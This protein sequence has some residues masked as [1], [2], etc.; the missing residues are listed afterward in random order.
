VTI[1]APQPGPAEVPRRGGGVELGGLSVRYLTRSSPALE[2]VSVA[3]R[4]GE[5]VGVAGRNGAGKSTLALAAA[6]FIP[7]I[8]RAHISGAVSI[9]GRPV[10]DLSNAELRRSVGIVFAT[11]AN[12]LSASKLTVREEL[13]FGLENLGF[14]RVLMEAR[15]DEVLSRLHIEHLADRDPLALSG[16]EQQRVAIASIVAMG[17]NALVLDEPTAQLDPAG[18]W[19]VADLL[20]SLTE[21]GVAVMCTEHASAVLARTDRCLVL[22]GG[23]GV[24]LD[25]PGLAL[26]DG[27]LAD[28]EMQPPTMAILADAA[29]VPLEHAFDE[30]RIASAIARRRDASVADASALVADLRHAMFAGQRPGPAIDLL[31]QRPAAAIEAI[32]LRHVYPGGVEAVR[33]VSLKVEPGES[34]AIVGQNGSGKTTLV[35]HFNGL[36]RPS[37]GEVRIDGRPTAGIAIHA[38]AATVGFVFQNPD[39]QLFDRSVE[40]EVA[41]GPRNLGFAAARVRDLVSSAISAVGLADARSTNPYDLNVSDRKLVALASVLAMDPAILVLDEPTTG[42]DGPGI[43]RIAAIVRAWAQSGRS[44]VAITHDMEFAAS[45]FERIIVMRQGE[46]VAD[47]APD[48]VFAADL[49]GLLAS[50][51]LRPPAAARIGGALGLR[52]G[53]PTLA[54]L[55]EALASAR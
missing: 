10:V 24:S 7:R 40:R 9:G 8:V 11:P 43:A 38:L 4:A 17:T 30:A 52:D 55:V 32:G 37:G 36:L 44:V 28:P 46:I 47:G 26:R 33:G 54:A 3:V 45:N 35:K 41:F 42:Q 16:G 51:G 22:V 14:A 18:A 23:R 31:S 13:A 5:F 2:E 12:Q 1:Q 21:Q 49:A 25:V 50:T 48:Q 6:G 34:V 39:D 15:I 53:T 19:S 20:A 29:G 27:A